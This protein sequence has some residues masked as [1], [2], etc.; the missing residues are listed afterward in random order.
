MLS[1]NGRYFYLAS[2][3]EQNLQLTHKI[4]FVGSNIRAH[5]FALIDSIFLNLMSQ[6]SFVTFSK[7]FFGFKQG[8]WRWTELI[9]QCILY[10]ANTLSLCSRSAARGQLAI[11]KKILV[12]CRKIGHFCIFYVLIIIIIK[13]HGVVVIFRFLSVLFYV[14]CQ[15]T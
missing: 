2:N 5:L 4:Q 6:S 14:D 13:F 15:R 7:D 10:R 11:R 9:T 3:E 8:C 1:G 12:I